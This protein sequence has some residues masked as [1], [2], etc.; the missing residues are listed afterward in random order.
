MRSKVF[1]AGIV[2]MIFLK[3]NVGNQENGIKILSVKKVCDTNSK[4]LDRYAESC[5]KWNLTKEDVVNIL[6][7][8]EKISGHEAHYFYGILPCSYKG[9]LIIN[10]KRAKF[11]INAGALSEIKYSDTTI[12][13]GYKKNDYKKYFVIGPGID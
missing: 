5:K 10:E 9:D 13:Y 7:S 1:L 11:I 4:Y 3:S 6:L 8:S 2:V 12:F